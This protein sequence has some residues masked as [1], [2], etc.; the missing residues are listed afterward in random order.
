[1]LVVPKFGYLKNFFVP[2]IP[3]GNSATSHSAL[4]SHSRYRSTKSAGDQGLCSPHSS[5]ALWGPHT[6]KLQI[7]LHILNPKGTICKFFWLKIWL[8]QKIFVTF[9]SSLRSERSAPEE[10]VH[11]AREQRYF[12]FGTWVAMADSLRRRGLR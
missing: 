12:A 9:L 8:C 5:I 2:L 7:N 11:S 4:E 3:R 10:T 6:K 1:M